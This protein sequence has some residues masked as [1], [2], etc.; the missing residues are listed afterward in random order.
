MTANRLIDLFGMGVVGIFATLAIVIVV[1][2]TYAKVIEPFIKSASARRDLYATFRLIAIITPCVFVGIALVC[3]LGWG[4]E[5]VMQSA[6][7]R[8][9]METPQ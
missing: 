4:V 2:W 5:Y 9:L 8:P 7:L 6:G 3:L 1:L